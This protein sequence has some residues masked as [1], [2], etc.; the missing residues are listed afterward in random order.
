MDRIRKI[1]RN[2]K[3]I[4][5]IDYS[6]CK[7]A[8]MIDLLSELKRQLLSHNKPIILLSIFNSKSFAT[9]NFMRE[10]RVATHETIHLLEKRAMVGL[11]ETKKMILKGYNFLFNTNIK[12][13]NTIEEAMEF[14]L[15]DHTTDKD[16][17]F[18]LVRK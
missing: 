11:S 12:T 15:D 16:D 6:D 10:A 13:F 14:L 5:I 7:E 3:E 1:T 4:V 9:P 2:N 8:E 17:S 18:R